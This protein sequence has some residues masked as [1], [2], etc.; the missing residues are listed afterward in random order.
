MARERSTVQKLVKR[1]ARA[2][3]FKAQ[4]SH[5]CQGSLRLC[6]GIQYLT[7]RKHK[8]LPWSPQLAVQF[9]SACLSRYNY[10]AMGLMLYKSGFDSQKEQEIF[11]L[12]TGSRPALATART[13]I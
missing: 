5:K 8:I 2:F 10:H 3:R 4:V 9:T 7:S 11:L 6:S 12:C 13:P 1:T